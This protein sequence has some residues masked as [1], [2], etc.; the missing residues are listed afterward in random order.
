MREEASSNKYDMI[1]IPPMATSNS[2]PSTPI[3]MRVIIMMGAV[4]GKYEP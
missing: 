1:P 4:N 2:H 3:G